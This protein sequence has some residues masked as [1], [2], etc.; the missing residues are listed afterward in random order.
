MLGRDGLADAWAAHRTGRFALTTLPRPTTPP[1]I[2]AGVRAALATTH[3]HLTGP[4][5]G[6]SFDA[7][8][9]LRGI[10]RL[11]ADL[12]DTR[13]AKGWTRRFG[14]PAAFAAGMSRLAECLTTAYTAPGATRP[15]YAEFLGEA[16]A[17]TGLDLHPAARAAAEAGAR[18]T[19]I[20]DVAGAAGPD[21]H[22]A[23]VLERLAE[24]VAAV[25]EVEQ[26]LADRLGT[27]IG[28]DGP[29]TG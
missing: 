1:D 2:A 27:A 3:A 23:T 15:L 22:P 14:E 26:R 17:L 5:L 18:W 6:H 19:E 4:V 7:N 29:P 10:R 25:A 20:A 11:A 12:A 24:G 8:M 9:G 13:A 16:A 21:D 28:A